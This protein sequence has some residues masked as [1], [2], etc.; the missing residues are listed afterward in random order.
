MGLQEEAV[1]GVG[2][3]R[4]EREREI[5]FRQRRLGLGVMALYLRGSYL[6]SRHAGL[7]IYVL[8]ILRY[9]GLSTELRSG[10]PQKKTESGKKWVCKKWKSLVYVGRHVLD[11]LLHYIIA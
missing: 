4:R 8:F 6:I 11:H 5:Y 7:S 9:N 1:A 3:H 10:Y 2:L